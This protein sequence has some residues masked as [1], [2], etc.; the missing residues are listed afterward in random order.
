RYLSQRRVSVPELSVVR[1][2]V[3]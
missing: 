1:A 3:K 2:V